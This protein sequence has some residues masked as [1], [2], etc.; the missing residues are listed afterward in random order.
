MSLLTIS[1]HLLLNLLCCVNRIFIWIWLSKL[2]QSFHSL[3]LWVWKNTHFLHADRKAVP[4]KCIYTLTVDLHMISINEGADIWITCQVDW[5]MEAAVTHGH[6]EFIL[7]MPGPSPPLTDGLT[8]WLTDWLVDRINIWMDK[9]QLVYFIC[10][11]KRGAPD[12]DSVLLAWK[13]RP[14]LL[15]E[16]LRFHFLCLCPFLHPLPSFCIWKVLSSQLL[17][18]LK[19][20]GAHETSWQWMHAPPRWPCSIARSVQRRVIRPVLGAL[21]FFFLLLLLLL[22][23]T[24]FG[25]RCWATKWIMKPETP[26]PNGTAGVG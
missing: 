23:F 12:H 5:F 16:W 21:L 22:T 7:S 1:F 6:R 18:G 10:I 26:P 8:A 17:S 11:F 25:C 24:C 19:E 9:I 20:Q 13:K 15:N 14:T 2:A 4:R 3:Q